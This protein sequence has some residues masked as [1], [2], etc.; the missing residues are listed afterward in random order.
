MLGVGWSVDVW[1]SQV[2]KVAMPRQAWVRGSDGPE[3]PVGRRKA[4]VLVGRAESGPG[5]PGVHKAAE[6]RGREP[7]L[8]R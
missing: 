5:T 3:W 4:K 6:G 1:S 8:G 2:Q 7:G